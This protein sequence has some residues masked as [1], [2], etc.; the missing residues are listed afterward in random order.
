MKVF[1]FYGAV[2]DKTMRPEASYSDLREADGNSGNVEE[3]LS[4][5]WNPALYKVK[6]PNNKV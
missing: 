5:Y 2:S 1:R 4:L 6:N 3:N